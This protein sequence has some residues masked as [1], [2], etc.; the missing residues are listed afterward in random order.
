MYVVRVADNFHYMDENEHYTHGTF[1]SW[2]EA[3]AAA[4]S[5]VD[6]CLQDYIRPG[7]SAGELYEQYISFGDDPFIVPTPEGE[8]FSGWAYAKARCAELL[9]S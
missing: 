4:R 9:G 2:A 3:L 5:I 1:A 8:R 6:E 7:M